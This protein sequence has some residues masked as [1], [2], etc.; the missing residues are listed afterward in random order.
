MMLSG[1]CQSRLDSLL[2]MLHEQG[3][4]PH[5]AGKGPES[6]HRHYSALKMYNLL[7][8]LLLLLVAVA[9]IMLSCVIF[10]NT[11]SNLVF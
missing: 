9:G 6:Q 1:Q 7:A 2:D 11:S 5:V 10:G 8:G 3:Q 4:W